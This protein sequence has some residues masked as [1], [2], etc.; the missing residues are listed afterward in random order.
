MIEADDIQPASPSRPARDDVIFRIDEELCLGCVGNISRPDR[1]RDVFSATQQE[2]AAFTGRGF[3]GV[4]NH[5]LHR[6]GTHLRR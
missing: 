1:L 3:P 6:R 4:S 5:R 2:A